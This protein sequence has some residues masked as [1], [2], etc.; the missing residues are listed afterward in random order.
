MARARRGGDAR[1]GSRPWRPTSSPTPRSPPSACRR[2]RCPTASDIDVVRLP[3]ATNARAK[4]SDLHDGF[5]KLFARRSTG[6]IIGGVV[7]A[8]GRV[9]AG[10]ADRPRRHQGPDRRRPGADVRDLPVAVGLDHRGRPTADGGR[11]T[12]PE[13]RRAG[14]WGPRGGCDGCDERSAQYPRSRCRWARAPPMQEVDAFCPGSD[15]LRCRRLLRSLVVA[16]AVAS[17]AL[18]VLPGPSPPLTS[19][20]ARPSSAGWCR[21]GPEAAGRRRRGG[22]GRRAGQLG[23]DRRGGRRPRRPDRASPASRPAR[24]SRSPSAPRSRTTE[25]R[26]GPRRTR[27]CDA[28]SPRRPRSTPCRA[29]PAGLTNRVTVVLV[30]AGRRRARRRHRGRRSSTRSTARSPTSGRSRPTARSRSASPPR[31]T[32]R[33]RPPAAPTPTRCGTR[34]P[35][36]SA[37]CPAPAST[38]CCTCS[39]A[40]SGLRLRAGRGRPGDDH[41]RPALR[42]R[43]AASVIAHELG[44]N[45]GLGHSSG[46]QCDGAVEGGRCRTVGLPRLLRRHGRLVGADRLAQRRRRPPG[47]ASCPRRQMQSLTVRRGAATVTLAPLAG[48]T[49]TRALRLTDAEGVDY[50]LEYRTATGR[51]AWLGTGAD[52][53]ALDAGVLLRRAGALPDTSVLLD[54]TPGRRGRLGRRLPGRAADRRRPCP[55]RAVTSRSSSRA[56]PPPGPS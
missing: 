22:R 47:S 32:G 9:G 42:Q 30:A 2:R 17:S 31:T 27:C 28:R 38:C 39:R 37:S 45:F 5:V 29:D 35:R 15:P 51:D 41:R 10:P 44:H 52:R 23:R 33:R 55:C 48:R 1:S 12:S 46:E 3:L 8:P 40:A 20:P 25:R 6:V 19:R 4:M 14:P 53:P 24:R 13:A 49:G 16:S 43:R 21:P 11:R 7:V 56:S 50:W 54:G 26:R 36:R 34:S 18:R